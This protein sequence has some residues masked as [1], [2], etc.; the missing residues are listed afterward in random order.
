MR[1]FTVYGPWGRPDMA[2]FRLID[3]FLN[4]SEFKKFGDGEIKRDF[5]Y[6]E[7]I[8]AAVERLS[9][10]LGSH[11]EGY[12]DIVN[13]GGG[14]PHSLNDLISIISEQ[15]DSP[16]TFTKS[17]SNPNDTKFTSADSTKILNLTG[18]KPEVD[19]ELG[20]EETIKWASQSGIR[21]NLFSWVNSTV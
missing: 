7:D 13:I 1:F 4:G 14:Q 5:T 15:L 10:E 6:I 12:S 16:P 2:Y 18:V 11:P 3:S 8:S 21:E 9:S 17:D 19:L 20:V